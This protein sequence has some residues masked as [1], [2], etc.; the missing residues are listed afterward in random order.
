VIRTSAQVLEEFKSTGISISSWARENG[1]NPSLVYQILRNEDIPQRGQSHRI[2]V[3]LG[4]K[5]GKLDRK[6]S[7]LTQTIS[8]KE[9]T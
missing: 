6:E 9:I 3:T 7:F 4:L 5:A 8:T 1:F 2:A